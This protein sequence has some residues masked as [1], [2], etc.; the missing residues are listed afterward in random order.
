[1][2]E[3]IP[4]SGRPR[5]TAADYSVDEDPDGLDAGAPDDRQAPEAVPLESLSAAAGAGE[6]ADRYVARMLGDVSRSRVQHWIALG[7]VWCDER[8]LAAKTKLAGWE[9]IRVRRLPREADEAF[10]PEPVPFAIVHEDRDLWIIDKPAGLVVHPAAGHWRGTLLNGLLHRDPAQAKLARAGIVHRLDKDTS[11]LMV[12][13]RSERAVD[14]LVAQ[15]ADRTMSRRYLAIVSGTPRESGVIDAPIGRDPAHRTRMAVV[16]AGRAARTH[17]ARIA[18]GTIDGRAV[19]LVECRLDTG[20][21]HQIR[22]HMRSIGHPLLGDALYGGPLAGIERQAL[23]AWSL[24]LRHPA[25]A[26]HVR[27]RST[28][29]ADFAA[30]CVRAGLALHACIV[31]LSSA[32]DAHEQAGAVRPAGAHVDAR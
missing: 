2:H 23:H 11:G 5:E 4:A 15:L 12:V 7:A 22:V 10:A 28:P 16:P 3:A 26:A 9:T 18:T 19:S 29:P 31:R 1:M 14:A 30:A 6:R 27:W 20:R 8:V 13:A 32:E 21:T 17:Y 24:A 25:D